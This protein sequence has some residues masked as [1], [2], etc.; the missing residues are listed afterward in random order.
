M[1]ALVLVAKRL[2][3]AESTIKGFT[4]EA[5]RGSFETLFEEKCVRPV[6]DL[7]V[8]ATVI[9]AQ[10]Q[11][12]PT[13]DVDA[14]R[15]ALGPLWEYVSSD[16]QP[17]KGKGVDQNKSKEDKESTAAEKALAKAAAVA[18][19]FSW[20]WKPA[21]DA[22]LRLFKI[23]FG[24]SAGAIKQYPIISALLKHE[25]RLPL[26]EC[27]AD[28]LQWHAVLFRALRQ[29]LRREEAAEMSN[30]QAIERLPTDQQADAWEVLR[31]CSE[32]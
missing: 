12:D 32:R 13:G 11:I 28:V 1:I 3:L 4:S 21:P 19:K 16:S 2:H 20:L 24:G 5:A 26:I 8:L 29:G 31:R 15:D 9:K 10:T 14:C 27:V 25:R 17:E 22:S 23:D 30:A 18:H 7:N 6:F